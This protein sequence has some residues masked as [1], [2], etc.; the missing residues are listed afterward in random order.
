MQAIERQVC[1]CDFGGNSWTSKEQADALI[2]LLGLGPDSDFIELGAGTGWPGIYIAR[3]CGCTVTLVDLQEIGLQI[4]LKRAAEENFADRVS[5]EVAD[6]A[7]LP[8]PERSFDA[9][10]HSDLLCCLIRKRTVLQ[11]SRRIIR[12]DGTMAFTV[13]SIAPRL[14]CSDYDRALEN[15]PEFIEAEENYRVLLE[16]T[17]WSVTECQDLTDEYRDSCDRQISADNENR[18]ELADLLGAEESKL[19][20]ANWHSKLQAVEDGLFVRE[21]F[22]CKPM[23]V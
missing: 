17:G 18:A 9:I 6:A 23:K 10:G 16:E 2:P 20:L 5:A 21:L 11:Q 13:I 15:A 22:V 14:G 1:G 3:T 8:F 7:D 4:A 19:R 12:D